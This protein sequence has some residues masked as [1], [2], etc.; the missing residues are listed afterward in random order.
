MSEKIEYKGYTITLELDPDPLNPRVEFDHIGTIDAH[1][2]RYDLSDLKPP[3]TPYTKH[4]DLTTARRLIVSNDH[5]LIILP[6]FVYDHSGITIR[7]TPFSDSWDSG[8]IGWVY[9][10]RS[11]IQKNWGYTRLTARRTNDLTRYLM[12]EVAEFDAYLTGNV[13]G[14]SLEGPNSDSDSCWGYYGDSGKA[15][16][17]DDARSY[18][19]SSLAAAGLSWQATAQLPQTD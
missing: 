19:D 11:T 10:T 2:R 3:L 12:D 9:L 16:A 17:L 14:Y 4:N 15:A 13:W 6:L 18:I 5:A 1:T 8:Q 7:T